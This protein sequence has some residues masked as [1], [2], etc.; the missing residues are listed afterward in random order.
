MNM[1]GLWVK[2]WRDPQSA[3]LSAPALQ[4]QFQLQP[5]LLDLEPIKACEGGENGK[6]DQL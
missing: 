4:L 5:P 3:C 2:S 6:L 1:K